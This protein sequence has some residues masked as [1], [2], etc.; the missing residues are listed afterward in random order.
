MRWN[1]DASAATDFHTGNALIP[2]SN[3]LTGTEAE[4]EGVIAIPRCVEL[5]PVAPRNTDVVNSHVRAGKSFGAGANFDVFDDKV[6]RRC[7]VGNGHGGFGISHGRN[8]VR[9]RND[10]PQGLAIPHLLEH[11]Q[12]PLRPD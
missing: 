11:H 12:Q 6:G 8:L 5:L 7:G 9:V 2:T 3:D 1:G 10:G 4:L